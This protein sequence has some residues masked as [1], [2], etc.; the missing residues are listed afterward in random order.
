VTGLS[1]SQL[2]VLWR[3]DDDRKPIRVFSGIFCQCV[4]AGVS[5]S[6]QASAAK[7]PGP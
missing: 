1:P 2:A 6:L 7:E 4:Q 3:A 5:P